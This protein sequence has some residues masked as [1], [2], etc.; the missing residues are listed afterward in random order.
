MDKDKG[1]IKY[2]DFSKLDI[3]IGKVISAEKVEGTD[4][5]IKIEVD[6]GE[7]R[8]LVAGIAD[9]YSPEDIVGK[10][11]PILANLEPRKLRGIESQGMI[12][13]ADLKGKAVLLHP[14]KKLLEG[15]KVC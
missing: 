2:E 6:I 10:Q 12:L 8:I 7:K 1:T 15:S 9:S 13:A 14:D 3:C 11:I 4:K 5:L